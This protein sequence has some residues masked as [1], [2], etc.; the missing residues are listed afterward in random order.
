MFFFILSDT[1][2]SLGNRRVFLVDVST[3]DGYTSIDEPCSPTN[4]PDNREYN[5]LV[6]ESKYLD[7]FIYYRKYQVRTEVRQMHPR[8]S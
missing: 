3:Y 7:R 1:E 8:W 5:V 2:G 4:G 6:K